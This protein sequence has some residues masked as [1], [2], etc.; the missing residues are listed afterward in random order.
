MSASNTDDNVDDNSSNDADH[1][2]NF[3]ADRGGD[4]PTS[5]EKF[6]DQLKRLDVG[7]DGRVERATRDDQSKEKET[8]FFEKLQSGTR[9]LLCKSVFD[10]RYKPTSEDR[11]P[12]DERGTLDKTV[13]W[14][15]LDSYL[16]ID[17][18][19]SLSEFAESFADAVSDFRSNRDEMLKESNIAGK[20]VN[21]AGRDKYFH[22]KANAEGNARGAGGAVASALM[23]TAKEVKDVAKTVICKDWSYEAATQDSMRDQA[24]NRAGRDLGRSGTRTLDE[25]SP[26]RF[27]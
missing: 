22:T 5:K 18:D 10:S 23:S 21:V 1:R 26:R 7:E 9:D 4:E 20:I 25:Y 17:F 14:L 3:R 15:G 2:D 19:Q 8:S 12:S 24:A 16:G 6:N 27:K 13:D 11:F